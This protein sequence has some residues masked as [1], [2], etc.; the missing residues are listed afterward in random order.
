MMYTSSLPCSSLTV[1][2]QLT[3]SYSLDRLHAGCHR[4]DR[5]LAILAPRVAFQMQLCTIRMRTYR[6]Q[7][8]WLFSIELFNFS[9]YPAC[10]ITLCITATFTYST[11][12]LPNHLFR[13][14]NFSAFYGPLRL[15]FCP[16]FAGPTDRR[17]TP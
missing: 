4:N 15:L 16:I 13:V 17:Q 1:Y 6:C 3:L 2:C 7:L 9:I 5:L 8:M 10:K 14:L 12:R 11:P